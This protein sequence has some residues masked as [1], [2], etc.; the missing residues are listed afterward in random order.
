MSFRDRRRGIT[1][2]G[3]DGCND[4]RLVENGG[5]ETPPTVGVEVGV[6]A[7]PTA[8]ITAT[9][10]ESFVKKKKKRDQA[11]GNTRHHQQQCNRD[12]EEAESLRQTDITQ[13]S[14]VF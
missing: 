3:A 13:C 8:V 10:E 9:E 14:E 1:E 2:Y 12:V 11:N 4:I 7:S 5:G 6:V